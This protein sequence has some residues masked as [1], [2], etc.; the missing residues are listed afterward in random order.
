MGLQLHMHSRWCG[1]VFVSQLPPRSPLMTSLLS[2]LQRLLSAEMTASRE[3]ALHTKRTTTPTEWHC[4]LCT[5]NN[6]WKE[7]VSDSS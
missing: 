3:S 2:L 5:Y 4:P 6:K 7:L 1:R